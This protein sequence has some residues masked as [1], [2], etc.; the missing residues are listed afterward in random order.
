MAD[1]ELQKRRGGHGHPDPEIR[2]GGGLKNIFST[3]W[4]SVWS[5]NKA[6]RWGGGGGQAPQAPLVDPPL[7]IHQAEQ[8]GCSLHD[9]ILSIW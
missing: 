2:G 9:V 4:A 1:P 6:G 5:K 3:L 7:S 8:P